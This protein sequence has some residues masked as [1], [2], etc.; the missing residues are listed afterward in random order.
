M[1]TKKHGDTWTLKKYDNTW[2]L[3]NM[4]TDGHF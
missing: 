1:D 3:R 2:T 4:T